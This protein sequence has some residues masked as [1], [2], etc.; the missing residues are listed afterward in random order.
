MGGDFYDFPSQAPDWVALAI[1]DVAGKG[2][3]AALFMAKLISDL[4]ATAQRHCGPGEILRA[5]NQELAGQ[6]RRGMFV[7][8]QYLLV[9]TATGEVLASNGGHVPLLWYHAAL[10]TL[11]PVLPPG[12]P[13]L[14]ILPDMVYPETTLRL[15]PG[16]R[17][18][19]LT[20]GV[21]EVTDPQ[22]NPFGMERLEE[23]IRA[24]VAHGGP[25]I[26]PILEAVVA[27]A[28][29]GTR[30]DDLTLLQLLWCG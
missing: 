6:T 18:V 23:A 14:G 26:P 11:E 27:F 21:L 16:D 9:N 19:L 4:R 24:A 8:A 2:V 20:D 22:G 15:S 25:L 7:T 1:G 29:R 10:G 12:G 30:R 3:P 5:M 28:E 17:L 13:P